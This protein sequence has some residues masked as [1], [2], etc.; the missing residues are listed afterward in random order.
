MRVNGYL[1]G[2]EFATKVTPEV[3][4]SVQGT[5]MLAN[6]WIVRDGEIIYSRS[7][8]TMTDRFTFTD[9]E[10]A[11]GDHYYYVR[12]IQRDEQMAWGSPVFVRLGE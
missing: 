11:P 8:E 1:M 10:V 2:E 6:I 5:D 7:P 12:V 4:V 3:T 9:T